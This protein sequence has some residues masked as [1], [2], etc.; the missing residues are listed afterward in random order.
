MEGYPE[1]SLTIL[2]ISG[3]SPARTQP[4]LDQ[5][6]ALKLPYRIIPAVYLDAESCQRL[7]PELVT[8][9]AMKAMAASEIGCA[10]AHQNAC[11]AALAEGRAHTLILEDDAE[12]SPALARLLAMRNALPD[13]DV[14]LLGRVKISRHEYRMS[15]WYY[16]VRTAFRI[17]GLRIGLT[18]RIRRSGALAYLV[19]MQGLQKLQAANLPVRTVADDWPQ[20]IADLEVLQ[21]APLV[22]Y[23]DYLGRG[24]EIEHERSG[25]PL[26]ARQISFRK[27]TSLLLRALLERLAFALLALR[28]PPRDIRQIRRKA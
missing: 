15:R 17:A 11:A 8:P 10:L 16:P 7:G 13:Y 24:S 9:I 1:D 12:L 2:V 20:F 23:E 18:R 14:I 25:Q 6:A 28:H 19:S 3:R 26:S 22:A 4:L 27:Q 5:L 21:T